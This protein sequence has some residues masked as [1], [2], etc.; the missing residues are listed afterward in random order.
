MHYAADITGAEVM[1]TIRDEARNRPGAITLLEFCPAVDLILNEHGHCEGR[2]CS[3]LT[4]M[5]ITS[6]GPGLRS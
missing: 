3:T 6:S 2:C 5:N 1:R 4:S